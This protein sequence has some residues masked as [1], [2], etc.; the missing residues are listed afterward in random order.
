M[1][2]TLDAASVSAIEK[3]NTIK[4]SSEPLDNI[5]L[6][7][8][9]IEDNL[10]F[11]GSSYRL[12]FIE[13]YIKKYFQFSPKVT[14]ELI[15]ETKATAKEKT[16][17]D[18]LNE[19]QKVIEKPEKIIPNE[20]VEAANRIIYTGNPVSTILTTHMSMHVG[21]ETLAKTLLVS[22]GI[23][24]VRNSD[25]IQPKVSGG[26]GKGKTHCCKAMIHLIPKKYRFITTLS[27]KAIYYMDIPAGAVVFSDDIDL[28]DSLQG[29]IKRSTSNYQEGTTYTTIDKNRNK[30]ELTIPPRITWWLTS[31]EDDQSLQLL[32]RQFGGGVDESDDQDLAVFEF[33]KQKAITGDVNLVENKDVEICRYIMQDIK[34]N[35]YTVLIPYADDL[36]WDDLQNRRNFP[37]FLDIVK[38]FAVLRHRQ[39]YHTTN[40]EIIANIE[41]FN[42]AKSLY[43]KRARNQGTK[44]NDIEL[45][46]CTALHG[47]GE[48]DYN[49][50]QK[51][52][53]VS[54]GRISQIIRGKGKGDTGLIHKV[55]GLV[56]EKQ[57]VRTDDNTTVNKTVCSIHDFNPFDHFE[58][59]ITLKEGAEDRFLSYYP[60]ITK[61]LP[62]K[63]TLPKHYITNIN[64][65]NN[66]ISNKLINDSNATSLST[67]NN[68][69]MK[70]GNRGNTVI[71]SRSM[72][73]TIGNKQD[74]IAKILPTK[75]AK[76]QKQLMKEIKEFKDLNYR[77]TNK[78]S[79]AKK[80]N[81]FLEQFIKKYDTYEFDQD[82]V[83]SGIKE[84]NKRKW[85]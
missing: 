40:N 30:Q 56:V 24:S 50:L 14:A 28:S 57:N 65:Y 44:L 36:E 77:T 2:P 75:Q 33:Q 62:G 60:P 1:E 46:F 35:T 4:V 27:D 49:T 55:K 64:Y 69:S 9:F 17:K 5:K 11:Y 6:A 76:S 47:A 7:I 63:N 23:Q 19:S 58:T 3:L 85:K 79:Y 10:S 73:E 38:S 15:S 32:N 34:E 18:K 61:I 42:D 51:K 39:R 16:T 66:N 13:T 37:I 45:K 31:V 74:N 81:M 41:D 8:K 26:S 68:S 54:Q 70:R 67:Q 53:G 21:D 43:T 80:D 29:L 52:L 84:H 82:R 12:I 78:I 22:M 83:I 59:I 72:P 48:L 25:G 20:I 71:N